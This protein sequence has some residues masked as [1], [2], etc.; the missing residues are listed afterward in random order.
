[1][2][3]GTI[4]SMFPDHAPDF[5][6]AARDRVHVSEYDRRFPQRR[7]SIGGTIDTNRAPVGRR[8]PT[9]AKRAAVRAFPRS[10]TKRRLIVE[11]LAV[12]H[13]DGSVGATD[14]EIEHHFGWTHQSASA[15]RNT[16]MNDGYVED[17]DYRRK[18][19]HSGNDAIVWKI[20]AHA[21]AALDIA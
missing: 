5:D 9:T 1:M 10:G 7:E 4:P 16:L 19:A 8:H 11:W 2:T 6:L 20:T 17:S 14:D 15:A 12:R 13:H 3:A 18:V 21:I